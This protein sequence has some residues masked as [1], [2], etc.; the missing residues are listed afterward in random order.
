MLMM[1]MMKMMRVMIHH[2]VDEVEPGLEED[3][4]ASM[5]DRIRIKM[6]DNYVDA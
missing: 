3:T 5:K 1:M 2:V 6:V 4:V